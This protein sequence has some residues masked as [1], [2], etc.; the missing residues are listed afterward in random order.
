LVALDEY[1]VPLEIARN[2]Q[3][4]LQRDG[5]LDATLAALRSLDISQLA[6]QPFEKEMLLDAKANL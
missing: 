5:N 1:G 2:L 3:A 4:Q 6:L